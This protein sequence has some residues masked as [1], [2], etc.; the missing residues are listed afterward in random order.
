MRALG[1][2]FLGFHN[3][4]LFMSVG[5]VGCKIKD[6]C[7]GVYED[8]EPGGAGESSVPGAADKRPTPNARTSNT[9]TITRYLLRMMSPPCDKSQGEEAR[10]EKQIAQVSLDDN[11]E[12]PALPAASATALMGHFAN[13]RGPTGALL[14]P[15]F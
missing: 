8:V 2:P 7:C 6:S 12:K 4:Q 3:A 10:T 15:Q 14:H 1:G 9:T 5:R 13:H 11:L